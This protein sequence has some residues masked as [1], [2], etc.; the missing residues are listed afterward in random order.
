M[1]LK[2]PRNNLIQRINKHG[3]NF[4]ITDKCCFNCK[5]LLWMIGIG[6]GLRCGVDYQRTGQRP[7]AVPSIGHSCERF[8]GYRR[9]GVAVGSTEWSCTCKKCT[10]KK[11]EKISQSRSSDVD[12]SRDNNSDRSVV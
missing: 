2:M 12:G 5:H 1:V 10:R 11:D 4:Q 3:H 9:D 6:M 8:D 7:P